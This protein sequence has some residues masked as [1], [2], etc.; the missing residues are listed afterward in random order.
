MKNSKR[1]QLMLAIAVIATLVVPWAALAGSV[2]SDALLSSSASTPTGVA[3]GSQTFDILVWAT[4]TIPA[5]KTGEAW[6]VTEYDMALD[7]TI[8]ANQAVKT[9]IQFTSGKNYQQNQDCSNGDT[10]DMLGCV[11]NP[12]KVQASLVVAASTPDSTAGT[13]QVDLSVAAGGASGLG[14]GTEDIGYVEVTAEEENAP[15]TAAFSWS[16]VSP[17][18]G[19]EVTFTDEST[20]DDGTVDGWSWDFDD[21][22][23]STDQDPKHTFVDDGTYCVCLTVTDDDGADSEPACHDV[24]VLNV[25][26]TVSSLTIGGAN[27]TACIGGNDVTLDFD[28][29]DPGVDDSPWVVDVSWGDGTH[30]TYD[31]SAQGSQTQGKHTYAAGT[32]TISVSVTDKDGGSGSNSTADGAVSFLWNLSGILQP[33]KASPPNSIFK[34]GS[35]IPTKVIVTDCDN[36]PVSDLTLKVNWQLLS[37]G[38]P[39]GE[40]SEPYSTSAA[41]TGNTMRFIGPP[42]NQYIFNLASK[43]CPDPTGTYRIWVT[44]SSTAQH[45]WAD[46]GLKSK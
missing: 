2:V 43:S 9:K 27:D 10:S 38:T 8:T 14:V 16:P 19:E 29:T 1:M 34:Y 30:T 39:T 41:D 15:P 13:L 3:I 24:T 12:Y 21:G 11:G 17:K 4:G 33:I 45:V 31:A 6:V 36:Q 18:E 35:T 20:G 37:G 7:G 44:I 5:D 40:I 25:A 46:I 22:G 26:P 28:F 23:T 32:Y 42:D